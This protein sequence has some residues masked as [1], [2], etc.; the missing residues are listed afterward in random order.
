MIKLKK[1]YKR[2][3]CKMVAA[4]LAATTVLAPLSSAQVSEAAKKATVKSKKVTLTVG[5]KKKIAIKNKKKK[6]VYTYKVKSGK[7][8]KV[9]KKGVITAKKAGKTTVTVKEKLNK[10]TRTVGKIKVTVKKNNQ[11]AANTNTKNTNTKNTDTKNTNTGK[12]DNTSGNNYSQN[13]PSTEKNTEKTTEKTGEQTTEKTSEEP[14]EQPEETE[15]PKTVYL[16]RFEDG[17]LNG[18]TNRGSSKL[19]VPNNMNHTDGGK[20]CL[21][22]DSRTATWHGATMDLKNLTK[23]GENYSFDSWVRLVNPGTYEIDMTLEYKEP[24]GETRW[25]NIGRVDANADGWVELKGS[26]VIPEYEGTLNVCFE[27][28]KSETE[29]F[30][31]DDVEIIGTPVKK[32]EFTM[33]DEKYKE[34]VDASLLSTG[35]NAKMKKVIE[36][37]KKGEDVT[38]AVIGGSITEGALAT[39]NSNCYGQ[40]MAKLF[41]ETFG[42]DGGKNVHFVNA[43]MSGTPSALGVIRYDRDLKGQMEY[44]NYGSVPDALFIEFAVN[45]WGE[46]TQ[47]GA[48]EGLIR[49]ALSQG[50]AV[51]L[52]FA[53]FLGDGVTPSTVCESQYIPYGQYYDLPM[54]SMG[55]GMKKYFAQEGFRDWYYGDTLHPNNTGHRLMADCIMNVL[56]KIDK[57][58]AEADNIPDVSKFKVK[59]TDSYQDI[60]MIDAS[61]DIKDHPAIKSLDAGGF[62]EKD[63]ATC[64]FQYEYMGKKDAQWFPNNFMHK[65]G[66]SADSLKI[67][68]NCRTLMVVYKASNS[69]E[70]GSADLYIDGAKKSTLSCFDASGWNNAKVDVVFADST[71]KEHTIELKMASGNENKNFTLIGFGIQ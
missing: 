20:N 41:G 34:M 36:K 45:D 52:V 16:N 56:N 22:V 14:G 64:A 5:Q 43:G 68:A 32:V 4:V 11:A 38:I 51:F 7:I 29:P 54:I 21:K 69:S 55:N 46:P 1:A 2:A 6:A 9:S 44:A 57:E 50:T 39:P 27:I 58:E 30:Y 3:A 65:K 35:N 62:T 15:E 8:A 60:T 53:A 71:A 61:T 23:V 42:K 47:G 48:Y 37:A 49:K 63:P 28:P 59:K 25:K 31:V 67:T 70:Y 24:N 26:Y 66:G 19:E 13:T 33:T 10:K 17:D 18:I 40:T 12:N